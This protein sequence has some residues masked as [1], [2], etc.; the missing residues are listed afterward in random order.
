MAQ[1]KKEY[2]QFDYLISY[3]EMSGAFNDINIVEMRN[4][5]FI[6]LYSV[7]FS[8][9]FNTNW[10]AHILAK[11]AQSKG[12]TLTFKHKLTELTKSLG[13]DILV[14]TTTRNYAF[15]DTKVEWGTTLPISIL[16]T[17]KLLVL[18]ELENATSNKLTFFMQYF[19]KRSPSLKP[20]KKFCS[21]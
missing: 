14:D 2:H 9:L 12:C 5:K 3:S 20:P 4:N 13:T 10:D 8:F 19:R 6:C 21:T 7:S 1:I 11:K 16:R 18:P 15:Y 17:S